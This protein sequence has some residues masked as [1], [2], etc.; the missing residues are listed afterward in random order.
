VSV[1]LLWVFSQA[2]NPDFVTLSVPQGTA[3]VMN[4]GD[5]DVM[6]GYATML[7]GIMD[8]DEEEG[9]VARL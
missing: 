5:E 8:D 4:V 6:T 2:L 1:T 9:E 3:A 7:P